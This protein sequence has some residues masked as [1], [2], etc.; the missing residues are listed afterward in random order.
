[1]S[2]LKKIFSGKK[3][4]ED[5]TRLSRI[6]GPLLDKTANDVFLA[7]KDILLAEPI[8]Y[9]VPAVWGAS[10]D[11]KLTE[12]QEEI[13]R[14]ITPVIRE[15]LEVLDTANLSDSQSFAISFMIRGLIISKITYMIEALKN[16]MFAL[17][18]KKKDSLIRNL[19]P[20][21]RA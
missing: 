4:N 5:I 8:T 3:P 18:M 20:V 16:K 19:E 14:R 2:L 15:T 17:D 13:N 21:G 1:M 12:N 11:G 10:K 6:I 9:I 7:H